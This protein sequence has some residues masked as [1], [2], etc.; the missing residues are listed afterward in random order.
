MFPHHEDEI[1]QSEAAN[2]CRFVNYWLH[3]AHL[4]VENQKMSKS[5][6]NFYTLRDITERGYSGREIRWVLLSAH[7]R[8]TLNFSFHGLNDARA[9]LQRLDTAILRLQE[10][11]QAADAGMEIIDQVT[12]KAEQDFRAGL[13]DDLN[14]SAALAALFDFIREVNRLMDENKLAGKAAQKALKI[15]QQFDTVLAVGKNEADEDV[16]SEILELAEERQQARK[17]K[18]FARADQIRDELETQ[19]WLIEDTPKGSR[20]KRKN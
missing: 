12:S 18:N 13:A 9:A 1:A 15:F 16:P 8:Q 6:G 3:C 11:T 14:I 7:Y 20:V 17:T 2:G 10:Q 4:M 19:G 5:L